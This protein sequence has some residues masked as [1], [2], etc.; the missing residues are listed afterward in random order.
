VIG[1]LF[2][3]CSFWALN[4]MGKA[5]TQ[6]SQVYQRHIRYRSYYSARGCVHAYLAP[7]PGQ[8]KT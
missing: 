4:Q 1:V 3:M 7:I 5:D 6:M 2:W 8:K